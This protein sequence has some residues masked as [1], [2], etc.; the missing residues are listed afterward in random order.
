[1]GKRLYVGNLSYGVTEAD[2]REVFAEAGLRDISEEQ[3]SSEMVH[4][5]PEQYWAFMYDISAPVVAGLAR[6][7]EATREQI[8]SDVLDLAAEHTRDGAVRLR[9]T[10]T[11]I[12]GAR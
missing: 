3:V 10:A 9:S 7:A 5:T 11:I 6:V 12:S 2:L 1:M 8:R 4:E